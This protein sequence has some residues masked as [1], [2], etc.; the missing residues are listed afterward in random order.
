MDEDALYDLLY[1][2]LW[3]KEAMYEE[4]NFLIHL[5]DTVIFRNG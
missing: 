3:S 4:S 5:P 2:I 1:H